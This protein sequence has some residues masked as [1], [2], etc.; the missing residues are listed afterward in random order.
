MK[1]TNKQNSAFQNKTISSSTK[2]GVTEKQR[3]LKYKKQT[4]IK[5]EPTHIQTKESDAGIHLTQILNYY[6]ERVEAFEKDRIQWY[7]KLENIRIKQEFV[8]KVEWELKKRQDEKAEL[9]RAL[10]QCQSA[11]F[12][13]RERIVKMKQA[14]DQLRIKGKENRQLIMELLDSNNSVEQHIYYQNNGAPEKIQSYS[15]KL[16]STKGGAPMQTMTASQMNQNL[17]QT[18]EE[19]KKNPTISYDYKSPNILRT[20]Y[21][22]NDQAIQIRN[23][24]EVLHQQIQEQRVHYEKVL[25][26]LRDEKSKYEED[27]RMK[28]IDYVEEVEKLMSK[29]QDQEIFNYQVIRDHV[30]VMSQYEVEER[31]IQEEI[32]AMRIENTQIKDQIREI[33]KSS[34]Q[35]KKDAKD[36]Y[37]KNALEYQEVFR[38]QQKAQKEN[39]AVIKDQYKKVQE[40]YKRKMADMQER[41]EKETKKM[42]VNERR[43]KHELEGYGSDLQNMKKKIAFYQ[44]YINKLR[45]LV[46]EDQEAEDIQFSDEEQE[47]AEDQREMAEETKDQIY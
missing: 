15:K 36:E 11:L 29:L 6:R 32:E 34:E 39:I 2:G 26:T 31:K 25:Q 24:V 38:D 16:L 13:E 40:I 14:A 19:H 41:L 23:E 21:L 20:I 12:T 5:E 46:E 35:K 9:E 27:Q 28:Y 47:D 43:R 30:D 45:K 44:K 8:H 18:I 4:T 33:H 10:Q 1:T 22:P 7:Q 37:E 3:A 17:R 42:E